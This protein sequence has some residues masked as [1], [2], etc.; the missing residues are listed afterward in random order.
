MKILEKN[1]ALYLS[2]ELKKSFG[3]FKLSYESIFWPEIF[4]YESILCQ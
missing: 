4:W 2:E 1:S 3:E